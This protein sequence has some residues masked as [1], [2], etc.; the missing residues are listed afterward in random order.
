MDIYEE[1]KELETSD[2]MLDFYF[3]TKTVESIMKEIAMAESGMD[4]NAYNPEWHYDR[5]G[6]KVCQGSYGLYQIACVN[7]RGD[8]RD[9]FDP[10]LNIKMA[11]IVYKQQGFKAWGVCRRTVDCTL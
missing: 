5:N 7:Y 11:Q 8:P 6:N 9:L 4:P 10:H 1:P 2:E 3:D